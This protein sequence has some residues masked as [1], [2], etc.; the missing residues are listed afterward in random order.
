LRTFYEE[1]NIFCLTNDTLKQ[2]R[3]VYKVDEKFEIQFAATF[4]VIKLEQ[5]LVSYLN[6]VK[7]RTPKQGFG[8][9]FVADLVEFLGLELK[10]DKRLEGVHLFVG[11][12]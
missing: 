10:Q 12:P 9:Q 2:Q 6:L 7:A 4:F 5:H 11:Q 8:S 1:G 3:T